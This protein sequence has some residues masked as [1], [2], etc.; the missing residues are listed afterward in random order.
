[1]NLVTP[2]PRHVTYDTCMCSKAT[3]SASDTVACVNSSA[4]SSCGKFQHGGKLAHYNFFQILAPKIGLLELQKLVKI[5][6]ISLIFWPYVFE[7][8]IYD[9]IKRIEIIIEYFYQIL[10]LKKVR[11]RTLLFF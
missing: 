2:L 10:L 11:I 8:Q 5:V 4:S 3:S 1:M 9:L 7:Y 6:A